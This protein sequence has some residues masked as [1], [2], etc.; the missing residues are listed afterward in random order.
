MPNM[1]Q[2]KSK[3]KIFYDHLDINNYY[4]NLFYP[5]Y[6]FIHLFKYYFP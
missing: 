5:Y 1:F 3:K 2:I 6:L 4:E